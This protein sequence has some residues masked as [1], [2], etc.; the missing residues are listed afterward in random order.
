MTL[1]CFYF[2][3]I[4]TLPPSIDYGPVTKTSDAEEFLKVLNAVNA[5]GGCCCIQ[6]KF[7]HGLQLSL[8]NTPDYSTIFCFTDAGAND[9]ELMEG[10]LALVTA[11]HCKVNW[12][13]CTILLI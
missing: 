7:W 12:I 5:D 3:V 2:S 10:V 8:I 9:A 11:K 1:C 6:E 4:V 13:M